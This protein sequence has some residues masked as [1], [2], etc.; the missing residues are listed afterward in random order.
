MLPFL[1]INV[2]LMT[3]FSLACFYYYMPEGIKLART[4]VFMIMSF[5]QLFNVFNL[6]SLD[7][8][9]FDIG[10]FSNRFINLALIVS[11][12]LL[13]LVTELPALASIFHFQSLPLR[14]IMLLFLLSS[15]VLWAGE[16]YKSHK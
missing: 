15:S 7:R 5:T 4:G 6:R 16:L 1:L 8:S 10:F 9:V 14:D 11:L 3:G 2:L 12:L 13:F